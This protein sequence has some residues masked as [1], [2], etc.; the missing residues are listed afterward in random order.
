M[1]KLQANGGT[2]KYCSK[3]LIFG[4]ESHFIKSHIGKKVGWDPTKRGDHDHPNLYIWCDFDEFFFLQTAKDFI[5]FLDKKNEV[6]V[7]KDIQVN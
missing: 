5:P 6:M 4:K 1:P 3:R 2:P 7:V